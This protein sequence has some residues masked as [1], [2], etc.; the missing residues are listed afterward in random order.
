MCAPTRK[1][2]GDKQKKMGDISCISLENKKEVADA[3]KGETLP[4]G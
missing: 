1:S 2:K 3:E 4:I